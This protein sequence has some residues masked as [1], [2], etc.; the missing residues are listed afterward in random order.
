[1][2]ALLRVAETH[3]ACH[4]LGPG[5][6]FVVWVQGCGIGCRECV[7]PQWIPFEGG[8]DVPVAELAERVAR[9]AADGLTISGGEP[10]AQAGALAELV[11]RV[12]ARR[13][14]SVLAYT[15]YTIEHLRQH[16]SAAQRR[17]LAALDVLVDGPYLVGRQAAVRWRGSANQ[18]IHL[19]TDR[20]AGLAAEPDESAGLQFEVA[21]DATVR[22][23]G[24]PPVAGLRPRLEEHLGLNAREA[25][26]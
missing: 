17:L 21:A 2:S 3:P 10:F 18:R 14:L 9:E 16:G 7:S 20:H 4:V 5:S 19:L 11:A 1:M 6:R 25:G 12:R 8:R 15:G 22:W 13:D 23:L 26:S 24:V